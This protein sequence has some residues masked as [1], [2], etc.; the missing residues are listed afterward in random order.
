MSNQP[1]PQ[2]RMAAQRMAQIM[3]VAMQHDP[4]VVAACA[5]SVEPMRC[6]LG[7]LFPN[8]TDGG[9]LWNEVMNAVDAQTSQV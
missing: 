5:S 3:I 4:K 6:A 9:T 8:I 1:T 7:M 2:Q